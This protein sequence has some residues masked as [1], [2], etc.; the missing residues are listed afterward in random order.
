MSMRKLALKG[1]YGEHGR[2]CF[3]TE[4]GKTGRCYMVDCGIMD[5]DPFPYPDVTEEELKKVDFLF[6]THCHKDHSGAFEF[7]KSRGF[8]GWLAASRMTAELSGIRYERLVYPENGF[9]NASGENVLEAAGIS[10]RYGR[11]GHCPG[12]LW[13]YIEDS[14]GSLFF[15][16]DYQE[17]SL[18][19]ACDP[20]TGLEAD[21]AVIDCAH[22]E[23]DRNA[24]SLRADL[25]SLTGEK[26]AAGIPVIFPVPQY[27]RGP[28]LLKF[29]EKEF[30][31]AGIR[32]DDG[33]IRCCS[34]MLKEP[35]WFQNG[36][37]SMEP[38]M[39]GET[40]EIFLIADTHLKNEKNAEYVKHAVQN[41]AFV[42]VT[43]RVRK[44]SLLERLLQEGKAAR[45][46][47]PHHQSRGDMERM[48]ARNRFGTVLPFHSDRME[49]FV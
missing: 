8:S 38:F 34:Q 27:G 49:I 30:P 4:Y 36:K 10:V 14:L 40:P 28:E 24:E 6:L 12:G 33:F 45:L 48:I 44:G 2:S 13:Y 15:S 20:V 5:T 43:G 19:Y 35:V 37:L 16:G 22:Q 1:G 42:M 29:L 9:R 18:F 39:E 47:F 25:S 31:K 46:L 32:V 23:T 41:G 11:S 7:F 21:L 26:L 3:L 17:D